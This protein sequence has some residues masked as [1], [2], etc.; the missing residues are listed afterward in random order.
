MLGH[1]AACSLCSTSPTFVSNTITQLVINCVL[2]VYGRQE[3][4][5]PSICGTLNLIDLIWL[6]LGKLLIIIQWKPRIVMIPTFSSH[7]GESQIIE[8]GVLTICIFKANDGIIPWCYIQGR[9]TW[10]HSWCYD[11]SRFS[12]FVFSEVP[13]RHKRI[14]I[15]PKVYKSLR[16]LIIH[17][18]ELRVYLN[19][20]KWSFK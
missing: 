15:L 16:D 17:E 18:N 9:Y 3:I 12:V 10:R 2:I 1:V 6:S 19:E 20:Y 13:K 7:H 4:S 5:V 11:S 14:I 8:R